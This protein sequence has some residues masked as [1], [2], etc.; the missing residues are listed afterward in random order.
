LLLVLL[1]LAIFLVIQ[2][3]LFGRHVYVLWRHGMRLKSL[4]GNPAA[5]LEPEGPAGISAD[6]AGMEQALH[7]IQGH[8]KPLLRPPWLPWPAAR[9]N[10]LALYTLLDAGT[11][12]AS[13]GQVAAGGLQVV[14]ETLEARQVP[15][16]DQQAPGMSEVLFNGL[17][18]ARPHFVEAAQ[19]MGS[20]V[21][22][23]TALAERNLWSPLADHVPTLAHYLRLGQAGLEA[24]AAAPALLGETRPITYM[25]LAQ[26]NDELRATGGFIT[27]I[28]LATLE[29]GRI[30][31]LTIR[32]SYEFDTFPFDHPYPPEPMLRYMRIEQW[33]T[34][35]GNWSPDF[36]TTARDTEDLFHLENSGEIAGVVAFDM[37]ALPA[38]I[39]AV[40]PL[41]LADYEDEITA[42]NVLQKTRDYWSPPL[43]E[44][45]TLE[46]WI[47]KMGWK[48]IKQ[49]WWIH[50]KDFMG[51][52]ARALLGRVQAS[53]QGDQLSQLF[54]AVKR[55]MDEKHILLSFDEPAVQRFL[56]A[57]GMDGAVDQE[58]PGDY[59]LALDTNMGYN[60]VNPNVEKHIAYQ[61]RLDPAAA[62]LATLTI[63][64]HNRSPAQAECVHESKIADT[65]EL[66]TQDCYWNY[67]RV[68]VP[69]GSQLL[70]TEGITETEAPTAKHGRTMFATF[71]VVPAGESRTVR[72]TYRL[73]AWDQ[74]EYRLLVQKQ[75]GTDAVPLQVRILFPAGVHVQSAVPK[76]QHQQPGLA[77]YDWNLRQDRSLTL[78]LK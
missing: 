10:L 36:P 13:V 6:L 70:S 51:V 8:L 56:V 3:A 62:P 76:P 4:L 22:E 58:T 1:I 20:P 54:W 75:A 45:I 26:N 47:E 19:Q 77:A 32:D 44:G 2:A 33:A 46:S 38:L 74:A 29:H 52:L 28:G 69:L 67:L 60:K 11:D 35:D 24:T 43:P 5:V 14:A 23:I 12:L 71:F 57:A 61:V 78:T 59:L 64:Y 68:Y 7:G 39:K 41:Y 37:L 25:I 66:M 49:D 73:P 40:G 9:E 48:Q 15:T 55:A 21:Q 34:R 30:V 31:D 42:A 72:F 65:Y 27:G 18:A 63:T 16:P 50:R 53:G 17:V